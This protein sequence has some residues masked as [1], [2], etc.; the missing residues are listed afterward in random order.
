MV[1]DEKR[2]TAPSSGT[3]PRSAPQRTYEVGLI[4]TAVLGATRVGGTGLTGMQKGGPGSAVVPLPKPGSASAVAYTLNLTDVEWGD[5]NEHL[6][7]GCSAGATLS[8]GDVLTEP[9]T[10]SCPFAGTSWAQPQRI[11]PLDVRAFGGAPPH[12]SPC[13]LYEIPFSVI[14]SNLPLAPPANGTATVTL[15]LQAPTHDGHGVSG[16]DFDFTGELR[17]ELGA[18]Q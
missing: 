18:A 13:G 11:I 2:A 16:P 17:L 9:F 3:V 1:D 4:V 6:V 15:L 12:V 7:P 14:G 10:V 5:S 8:G